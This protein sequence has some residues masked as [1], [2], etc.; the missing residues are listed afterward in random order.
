MHPW[1][2]VI[3]NL[4]F[5]KVKAK[6]TRGYLV[7]GNG[8]SSKRDAKSAVEQYLQASEKLRAFAIKNGPNLDIRLN[9]RRSKK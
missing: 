3:S 5:L 8:I 2:K 9:A 4:T 1:V 7:L 6:K